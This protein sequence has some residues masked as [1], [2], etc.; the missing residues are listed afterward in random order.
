VLKKIY[1]LLKYNFIEKCIL[2][3]SSVILGK[4]HRMLISVTYNSIIM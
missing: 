1:K 4:I 3:Y 2:F